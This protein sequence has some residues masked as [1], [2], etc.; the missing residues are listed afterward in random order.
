MP[1]AIAGVGGRKREKWLGSQVDDPGSFAGCMKLGRLEDRRPVQGW[2][3][4]AW[5]G[6]TAVWRG[7]GRKEKK[8]QKKEGALGLGV[9]WRW[10]RRR[11]GR[12][13]FPQHRLC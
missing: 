9:T 13:L 12:L 7:F 5:G 4:G 3:I 10:T 2:M 6:E 1:R 8:N 11:T